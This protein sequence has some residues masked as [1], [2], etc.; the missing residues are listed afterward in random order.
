MPKGLMSRCEEKRLYKVADKKVWKWVE[1][2]VAEISSDGRN[3]IRCMHCHGAIKMHT[4]KAK[5]APE[6]QVVHRARID[7]DNCKGGHEFQGT[8]MLSSKPVE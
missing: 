6:D 7:T 5:T 3:A 4:T 2:P 1:I 8:A